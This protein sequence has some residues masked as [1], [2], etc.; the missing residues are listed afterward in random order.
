MIDFGPIIIEDGLI[1]G[2][3]HERKTV[4]ALIINDVKE[5]LMVYSKVFDDYTFPGGGVKPNE[6]DIDALKRELKEELGA[7]SIVVKKL[8]GETRELRYGIEGS[9]KVYLQTSNYYFCVITKFGKQE[10]IER[11]MMHGLEPRWVKI[12][13]ALRH[14]MKVMNNNQHQTKGLKTVLIRENNVLKAL[15]EISHETI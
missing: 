5:L 3:Q 13:D 11:E 8:A 12:E 9:D 1:N 2:I 10:L 7:Q 14:N 4:R 6:C 15:K